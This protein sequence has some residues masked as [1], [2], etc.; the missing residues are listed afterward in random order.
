V[1]RI[2]I[3]VKIWPIRV[4]IFVCV[5]ARH[6]ATA[7]TQN[8]KHKQKQQPTTNTPTLARNLLQYWDIGR[9][10]PKRGDEPMF[11]NPQD[12]FAALKTQTPRFASAPRL[13]PI[14]RRSS[15]RTKTTN[16]DQWEHLRPASAKLEAETT[17]DAH[18]YV[19]MRYFTR[20]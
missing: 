18:L 5:M 19:R 7:H 9:S 3:D 1:T 2:V 13:E 15:A 12:T 20:W 11:E 10:V 4:P 8:T 17:V 14:V 6:P 16:V